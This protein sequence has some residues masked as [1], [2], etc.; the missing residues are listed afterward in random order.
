MIDDEYLSK[1]I[2]K[3]IILGHNGFVGTHL[4]N[5]FANRLEKVEVIGLSLPDFDLARKKDL[6]KLGRL[7]SDE[8]VLIIC[9][10]IKRQF[11][12]TLEAFQKNIE[13][14]TNLCALLR[15]NPVR[16]VVYFS[17]AAVYGEDVVH[18]TISEATSICPTSFYGMAKY[19]SECILTKTVHEHGCGNLIILR[20]TLIYGPGDLGETYGPVGFMKKALRKETIT[21]WGD[22]NEYREFMYVDDVV[23]IINELILS[24]YS[25]VLNV[26]AGRSYTFRD[27]IEEISRSAGVEI[28]VASK[29]R[30]KQKVDN[31]FDNS[32]LQRTLPAG[33]SFVTLEEGIK[34]MLAAES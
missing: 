32:L 6:R 9:A 19:A 34:R 11:G 24:D 27:V 1:N 16:D 31:H 26:V 2:R 33:H 28:A 10:A 5:F 20:P 17:S 12:D 30:T 15:D 23:H 3:I 25:G 14:L 21:L 8:V 7:L 22:G 4:T 13:I 29:P 18:G